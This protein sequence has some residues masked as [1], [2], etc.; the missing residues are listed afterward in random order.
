LIL[1]SHDMDDI[2]KV[3][4]RVVVINKGIKVY[5]DNLP[6]LVSEYNKKKFIKVYFETL[7]TD[8]STYSYAKGRKN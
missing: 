2:E 6:K 4:D 3:C 1:T 7:P 8:L 5:D